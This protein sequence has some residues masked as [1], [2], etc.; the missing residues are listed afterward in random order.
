[1][2]AASRRS[3]GALSSAPFL[4]LLR[5]R[6]ISDSMV[7]MADISF[8]LAGYQFNFRSA[9]LVRDERQLL[10]CRTHNDDWWYLPGGRIRAGESSAEA[11]RRELAEELDADI[12]IGSTLAIVENFFKINLLPYHEICFYFDAALSGPRSAVVLEDEV[13]HRDWFS[14]DQLPSIDVRPPIVFELASRGNQFP[15]HIVQRDE[16]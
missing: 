1:M 2:A 5:L 13:E 9:A 16:K 3:P 10:L 15:L 14:L 7:C 6:L 4:P 11:V 8:Q 12:E